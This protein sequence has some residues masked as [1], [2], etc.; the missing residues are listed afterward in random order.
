[1]KADLQMAEPRS[2]TILRHTRQAVEDHR[3]VVTSFAND[4]V[5]RYLATH[6]MHLRVVKFREPM[7]DVDALCDALKHNAQIVDRYIKGVLKAFPADL[8]EAWTE[9]LPAPYRSACECELVRR[10]GFLGARL[11]TEAERADA[12]IADVMHEFADFVSANGEAM[13]DGQ[14]DDAERTRTVREIDDVIAALISFRQQL[15]GPQGAIVM[16]SERDA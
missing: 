10:R 13:V 9:A 14:Y 8:E 11:R 16:K 4:V 6:P 1:M 15:A 7:G 2:A 5:D 3:L 12:S